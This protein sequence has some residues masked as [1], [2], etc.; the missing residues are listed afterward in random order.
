MI[1]PL[2]V[3]SV[4]LLAAPL[5]AGVVAWYRLRRMGAGRGTVIPLVL[6]SASYLELLLGLLVRNLIGPDYSD[7]RAITIDVNIVV[8][9][10]TTLWLAFRG[11]PARVPGNAFGLLVTLGWLYLAL[12][13]MAA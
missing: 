5:P 3:G 4:A 1:D 2:Y 8:A 13:S 11:H 12:V 6:L 10:A 9:L 7:R